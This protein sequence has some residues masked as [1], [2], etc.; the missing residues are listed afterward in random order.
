[1]ASSGHAVNSR[2]SRKPE[3]WSGKT[4]EDVIYTL[5]EDTW[6]GGVQ[7]LQLLETRWQP[8]G[9]DMLLT[10]YLPATTGL[11]GLQRGLV[12]PS[13]GSRLA[14]TP[15]DAAAHAPPAP[16]ATGAGLLP[17]PVQ[18]RP[19]QVPVLSTSG[20]IRRK[21]FLGP[22]HKLVCCAMHQGSLEMRSHMSFEKN[23]SLQEY[24]QMHL[25]LTDTSETCWMKVIFR[26]PECRCNV[27]SI[28]RE[29]CLF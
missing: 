10:G 15:Q 5:T 22:K 27:A 4:S 23:W 2:A 26:R 7:A 24:A 16:T 14:A 3:T 17:K 29:T 21:T 1:M 8:I 13:E 18:R 11:W 19:E 28:P 9:P 20:V 25:C 6:T 12:L